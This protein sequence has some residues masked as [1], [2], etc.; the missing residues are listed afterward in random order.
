MVLD[1]CIDRRVGPG[2]RPLGVGN[3]S[4]PTGHCLND[5]RGCAPHVSAGHDSA[6]RFT[7]AH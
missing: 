5:N 6:P 7:S 1:D 3:P 2:A 4:D